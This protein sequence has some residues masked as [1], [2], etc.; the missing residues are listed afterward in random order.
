MAE[1][2]P[3]LQK[4]LQ[5]EILKFFLLMHLSRGEGYPYALLKAI[6]FKRIWILNGLTK[7]DLYNTIK[8]L[9]NKGLIKGKPVR[10][11]AMTQKHYVLT[12]KGRVVARASKGMMLKAFKSVAETLRRV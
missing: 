9:E 11:G 7:N 3:N 12:P 5:N 2:R 4:G 1:N 8:S 6:K 10:K